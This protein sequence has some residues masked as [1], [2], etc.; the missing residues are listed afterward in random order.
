MGARGWRLCV[1]LVAALVCPVQPAEHELG[2]V[3]SDGSPK[4][5]PEYMQA[6]M[7]IVVTT[8]PRTKAMDPLFTESSLE[9]Q[10]F[11]RKLQRDI[12]DALSR[13]RAGRIEVRNISFQGLR[14][15][16][17]EAHV[18]PPESNV[19]AAKAEV[20]VVWF[21]RTYGEDDV[22]D[23][24]MVRFMPNGTKVPSEC[25]IDMAYKINVLQAEVLCT[26]NYV[27]EEDHGHCCPLD[28]WEQVCESP[29]TPPLVKEFRKQQDSRGCYI[30]K[31]CHCADRPIRRH[32]QGS[33]ETG[34]IVFKLDGNSIGAAIL[35]GVGV[36]ALLLL[37]ALAGSLLWTWCKRH[38][39][40]AQLEKETVEREG[41]WLLEEEDAWDSSDDEAELVGAEVRQGLAAAEARK[42]MTTA[43][44][45]APS[46]GKAGAAKS[47]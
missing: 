1:L 46:A 45:D 20:T 26:D 28:H 43:D 22:T 39:H 3:K 10:D 4:E 7:E 32:R 2:A 15:F 13:R 19:T 24:I 9:Q 23:A 47:P 30:G 36:L 5:K 33:G 42:L 40:E 18:R 37:L 41:E 6:R 16:L 35:G 11:E 14:P 38:R 17:P 27:Y 8:A 12:R 29:C 44:G 21:D 25:G 31:Q 34:G